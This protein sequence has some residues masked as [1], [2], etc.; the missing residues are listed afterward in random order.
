M[1]NLVVSNVTGPP[2]PVYMAGARLEEAYPMGPV[3]EGAGLNVTVLSYCDSVD[4]G[5][6]A[7][8]NLVADVWSLAGPHRSRPSTSSVRRPKPTRVGADPV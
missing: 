3:I 2:F 5:F 7:S 6:I 8:P 4:V 1:H